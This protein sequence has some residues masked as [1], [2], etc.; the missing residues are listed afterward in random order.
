MDPFALDSLSDILSDEEVRAKI[1]SLSVRS[2]VPLGVI[3]RSWHLRYWLTRMED[4]LAT[5]KYATRLEDMERVDDET[6]IKLPRQIALREQDVTSS[7]LAVH[8][9][10]TRIYKWASAIFDEAIIVYLIPL[11]QYDGRE[12]T[13][14]AEMDVSPT[15]TKQEVGEGEEAELASPKRKKKSLKKNDLQK[16]SSS[17]KPSISSAT[18]SSSMNNTSKSSSSSSPT[19]SEPSNRPSLNQKKNQ[20]PFG[21]ALDNLLSLIDHTPD[22]QLTHHKKMHIMKLKPLVLLFTGFDIFEEKL[23]RIPFFDY[24]PSATASIA[25]PKDAMLVWT[26]IQEFFSTR[27]RTRLTHLEIISRPI[28]LCDLNQFHVIWSD[29]IN[30]IATLEEAVVL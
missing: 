5:S 19:S 12:A 23:K 6:K 14:M 30:E 11:D 26:W 20:S 28:N 3:R 24:F 25:D 7:I 2:D 13:T 29:I 1:E 27:L 15:D 22:Y 8:Q 4:G 9:N 16:P 21:G 10:S 17:S 18:A